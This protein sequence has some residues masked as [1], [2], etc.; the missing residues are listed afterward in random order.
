MA[1]AAVKNSAMYFLTHKKPTQNILYNFLE[2]VLQR[3]AIVSKRCLICGFA[4]S[5]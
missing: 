4:G 1:K 5:G 2:S 3:S